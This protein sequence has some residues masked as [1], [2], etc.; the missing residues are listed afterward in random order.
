MVAEFRLSNRKGYLEMSRGSWLMLDP[1][2]MQ[3]ARA[4]AAIVL[5]LFFWISL[6]AAQVLYYF[7]CYFFV[8]VFF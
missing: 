5:A 2:V 7:T 6:S 1:V 3:G 4:S 8:C